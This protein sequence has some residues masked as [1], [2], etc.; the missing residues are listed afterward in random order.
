MISICIPNYNSASTIRETINSILAQTYTDFEL[1]VVDNCSTDGSYKI[2]KTFTDKR[3]KLYKNNKNLGCGG[4][5]EECIKKSSNNEIL[6]VSADDII[7]KNAT[8]LI[9]DAFNKSPDIGVVLRPY[10]WFEKDINKP[11]RQTKQ[12]HHDLIIN[13]NTVNFQQIQ[14]AV[15]LT[16]QI[17]GI[18]IRKKFIKTRVI[19]HPFIEIASLILPIIRDHKTYILHQNIIAVR[20]GSSG[21]KISKVYENSPMMTWKNLIDNTY[22]ENKFIPIRN[23]L[24]MNFV[25]TNYIGLIQIKN[26]GTFY[27]L[28]REIY[29]LI[30][31]RP[32]NIAHPLFLVYSIF[33]LLCPK[34]ILQRL[35][36]FFK[37]KINSKMTNK[38]EFE[39]FI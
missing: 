36:P 12:F 1:V 15:A 37:D 21:S 25:A 13:P 30:I 18:A 31:L 7:D 10:F 8:R 19:N 14:D 33:T 29:Y 4:N 32:Q 28:T 17:S 35:V 5:L 2:I 20:I 22:K 6:F 23:Y 34:F 3:I 39:Y 26:Y 27:Q 16:D 9:I 11:L 24:I 38:I